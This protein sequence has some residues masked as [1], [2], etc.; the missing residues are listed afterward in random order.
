MSHVRSSLAPFMSLFLATLPL[1]AAREHGMETQNVVMPG[2]IQSLEKSS[3]KAL[4]ASIFGGSISS[5]IPKV[6]SVQ[7]LFQMEAHLV[8]G[9]GTLKTSSPGCLFKRLKCLHTYDNSIELSLASVF[10]DQ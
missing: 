2:A 10:L 3:D 5:P 4:R 9:E 7:W 6:I 8:S 1:V